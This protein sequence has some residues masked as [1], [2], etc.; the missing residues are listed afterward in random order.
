M[1]TSMRRKNNPSTLNNMCVE[2]ICSL[3]V[4]SVD[5]LDAA[6]HTH[7]AFQGC[8]NAWVPICDIAFLLEVYAL[9]PLS[10]NYVLFK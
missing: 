7:A 5:Y 4:G 3:V 6:A 1:D 2:S 8:G 9:A 10:C